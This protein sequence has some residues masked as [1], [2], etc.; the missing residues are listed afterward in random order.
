MQTGGSEGLSRQDSGRVVT[1]WQEKGQEAEGT[2]G[3]RTGWDPP[4]V[5]ARVSQG[6]GPTQGH[7][8]HNRCVPSIQWLETD[9]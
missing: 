7:S 3:E 6:S 5:L 1:V 2:A 9:E 8:V 4:R